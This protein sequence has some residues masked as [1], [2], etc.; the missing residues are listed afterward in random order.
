[1]TTAVTTGE[2]A[3]DFE[4]QGPDGVPVRLSQ[5]RGRNVVL[6]FYPKAFT[7]G[8]TAQACGLR[9]AYSNFQSAGIEVIGVSVD[10]VETQK[11][12]RDEYA[13]PF[14]VLA[15][16]GGA[17]AQKYGVYGITKKDGT[18]LNEARR[19]TFMIDANGVVRGVIDP[20][21]ADVHAAEVLE[22]MKA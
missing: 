1:M 16:P 5:F 8:C 2:R 18:V 21:H 12:F 7:G 6:Y 17:V 20:A 3:P 14:P 22:A 9:D 10:D 4:L 13:L 11:R 15:D 19:V